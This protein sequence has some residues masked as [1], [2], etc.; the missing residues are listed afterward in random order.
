MS[1]PVYKTALVWLW[2]CFLSKWQ[3][4][5]RVLSVLTFSRRMQKHADLNELADS[6][7]SERPVCGYWDLCVKLLR[8]SLEFASH[9][10]HWKPRWLSVPLASAFRVS[11]M[12][13]QA[14]EEI[15]HSNTLTHFRLT[16]WFTCIKRTCV[17]VFR[18][19]YIS[20]VFIKDPLWTC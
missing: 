2:K 5:P 15:I 12:H 1:I 7:L 19:L 4:I 8:L 3:T 20:S 14:A 16:G 17:C 18:C 13:R 11:F 9:L 10:L 6:L